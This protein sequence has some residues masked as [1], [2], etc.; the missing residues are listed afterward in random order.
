MGFPRGIF[1]DPVIIIIPVLGI[2]VVGILS[3]DEIYVKDT[4]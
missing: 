3:T 1:R 4:N 2:K